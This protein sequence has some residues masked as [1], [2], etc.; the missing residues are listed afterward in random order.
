LEQAAL[1][2]CFYAPVTGIR[3]LT[4]AEAVASLLMGYQACLQGRL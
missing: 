2:P 3:K 1:T 4:D